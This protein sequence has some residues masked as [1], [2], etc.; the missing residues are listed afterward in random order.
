L[1]LNAEVGLVTS[2]AVQ[3]FLMGTVSIIGGFELLYF[4]KRE[5]VR[6]VT[7]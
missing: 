1:S 3:L 4:M 7:N 6:N 2:I 5:K